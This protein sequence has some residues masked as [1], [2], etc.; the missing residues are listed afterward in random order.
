MT[1]LLFIRHGIAEDWRPGLPDS[2]RG[3]TE[4]GW[5]KTRKAM[6]GILARGLVPSRGISS[7]Y[8]RAM[9]TMACLKEEAMELDPAHA[10]PVG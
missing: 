2:E 7:P 1:T 5:T 3:L 8:R 6:R 4:E 10:F 9:E